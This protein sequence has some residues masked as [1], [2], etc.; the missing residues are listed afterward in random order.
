MASE[1]NVSNP[2]TLLKEYDIFPIP[3][4]VFVSFS[5]ALTLSLTL[6]GPTSRKTHRGGL[7]LGGSVHEE[8][9][10]CSLV[11][12]NHLKNIDAGSI[13][14]PLVQL[15]TSINQPDLSL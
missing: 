14:Y 5:L 4:A 3:L 10:P 13:Y 2:T 12:F 8:A 6:C 9:H 15:I 11:L 1:K 7:G